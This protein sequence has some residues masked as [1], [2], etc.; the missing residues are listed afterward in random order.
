MIR[1]NI[2]HNE[3][4]TFN[5]DYEDGIKMVKMVRMGRIR[6]KI[7]PKSGIINT[8]KGTS[9]SNTAMRTPSPPKTP[10][11]KIQY[12][13]KIINR[14]RNRYTSKQALKRNTP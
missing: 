10:A 12:K 13:R 7:A 9:R 4:V 3:E 11:P 6:R 14:R 1:H 5:A 2:N 8:V